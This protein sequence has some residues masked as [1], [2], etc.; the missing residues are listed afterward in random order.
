ML[1]ILM[2][3]R[4]EMYLA[5]WL[6][7]GS[8]ERDDLPFSQPVVDPLLGMGRFPGQ[9]LLDFYTPSKMG[10]KGSNGGYTT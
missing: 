5:T 4:N 6:I 1:F 8:L 9:Y 10:F 7:R 2:V 3:V